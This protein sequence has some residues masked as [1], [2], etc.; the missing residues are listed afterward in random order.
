MKWIIIDSAD[1]IYEAEDLSRTERVL[2][3]KFSHLCSISHVMK[4]LLQREWHEGEMRMKTYIVNVIDNH[5]LSKDIADRF[6]VKHESPQVIILEKGKAVYNAS[7][8]QVKFE[9]LQ[10]YAN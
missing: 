3:F 2:I 8:G 6:K 7:H 4:M 10:Q 9:N 1:K 5:E